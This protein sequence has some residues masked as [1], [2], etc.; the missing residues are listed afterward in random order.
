MPRFLLSMAGLIG[1]VTGV[2]GALAAVVLLAWPPQ[3]APGPVHYPF[4]RSGFYVAQVVFF[5]HHLGLVVLLVGLARSRAVGSGWLTRGAAWLAV[6]GMVILSCAELNTMR[7]ADWDF[8]Q[9]NAG[10]VG[11]SY[12]IAC[13]LVGLGL[14]IAGVGAV[15]ARLWSGWHRWMPLVIGIATFVELTPGMFGGFIVAR[16]AI[17]TWMLLFAA[18]G[19]SLRSESAAIPTAPT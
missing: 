6:G 4:T 16:L 2:V 18:L 14:L 9:A 10:L 3:V 19:Q 1:L 11:A 7:F 15:R 13:N 17:G 12:G 5:V 8:A